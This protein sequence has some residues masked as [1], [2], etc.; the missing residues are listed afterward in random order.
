[1]VLFVA[2]LRFSV[3]DECFEG[4]IAFKKVDTVF[5]FLSMLVDGGG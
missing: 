3:E 2:R 5:W 4:D 1:M